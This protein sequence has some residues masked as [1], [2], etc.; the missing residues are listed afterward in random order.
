MEGVNR[1]KEE[2]GYT[3]HR[4][5]DVIRQNNLL[6]NDADLARFLEVSA[7]IICKVRSRTL[8]VSAALLIRMHEATGLA[9]EDLRFLMGDRRSKVRLSRKPGRLTQIAELKNADRTVPKGATPRRASVAKTDVGA[10][11]AKGANAALPVPEKPVPPN[12]SSVKHPPETSASK[13]VNATWPVPETSIP[14]R[15][16][17]YYRPT[18]RRW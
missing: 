12:G 7:P 8:A 18:T 3:P 4:L 5:L 10:W 16:K 14:Q 15:P 11:T 9:I 17:K 1:H 13:P 2:H 6:K